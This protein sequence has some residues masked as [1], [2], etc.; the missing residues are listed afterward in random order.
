MHPIVFASSLQQPAIVSLLLDHDLFDDT[1]LQEALKE[2]SRA[3]SVEIIDLILQVKARIPQLKCEETGGGKEFLEIALDNNH[4]A[5]AVRLLE[6]IWEEGDDEEA[7]ARVS[8]RILCNASLAG[9]IDIVEMLLQR[10]IDVNIPDILGNVAL[11]LAASKNNLV[12]AKRLVEHGANIDA[13]DANGLTPLIASAMHCHVETSE[14]LI[15]QDANADAEDRE[16][17]TPLLHAVA[18]NLSQLVHSLFME[19][20]K[21]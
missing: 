18:H 16:G 7:K 15:S 4:L 2:A 19:G 10:G 8:R 3:G 1:H 13:I 14:W 12:V 21:F 6:M 20:N 5:A 11:V 9:K 17:K